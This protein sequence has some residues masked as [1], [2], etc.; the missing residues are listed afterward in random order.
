MPILALDASRMRMTIFSPNSVGSVLMRKLHAAVLR[1]SLLGDVQAADDL[2]ARRELVLDRDRR[3]RDLA[4]FAV[5]A[6]AHPIVVFVGLEVQVRRA[7]IDRVDQHLLQEAHH[8][9]VLDLGGHLG[10]LG[11]RV[12]LVGDVE[13]EVGRG[14]GVQHLAGAGRC[15]LEQLGELVVLDDDPLG[16]E[17]GREFDALRGF[18]VRRICTADEQ[19]VPAPAEDD[20]LI[21]CGEL[22]VDH[23]LGQALRVHRSQ[24]EQRQRQR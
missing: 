15:G 16:R 18:L 2:D 14:Q 20:D 11:A 9:R 12:R 17:L 7:R 22:A 1:H 24:V 10:G 6:K 21:L 3:L 23:A 19:A 13:L 4:Q 8:R 5:D